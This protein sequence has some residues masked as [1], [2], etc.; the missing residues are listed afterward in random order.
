MKKSLLITALLIFASALSF[1]Q[2]TNGLVAYY[3]FNGNANDSSG[4]G[5]HATT[6]TAISVDDR[7]GNPNMAYWF[8][9]SNATYIEVPHNSLLN[10]NKSKTVSAWYRIDSVPKNWYPAII[11]KESV[12]SNYPTF[13]IQFNIDPAYSARNRNK[14]GF[15][16]GNGSTNKLLSTQE[17]ITDSSKFTKWVHIVGTYSYTSGYQKIYYNGMLSD[18]VFLGAYTSD[19]STKVMQIGRSTSVGNFN[20]NNFLGYIDDIRLYNRELDATEISDLFNESNPILSVKSVNILDVTKVYPNPAT[21]EVYIS[22]IS[23][24]TTLKIYDVN[25]KLCKTS[26]LSF[27]TNTINVSELKAGVYVIQL[28]ANGF[29]KNHKLIIN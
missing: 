29:S 3:P 27:E 4:N 20:G 28:Q 11:Y 24:Q 26:T 7:F 13:G 22:N 14:V 17:S 15:F 18:S 6:N 23:E 19:T 5:I 8:G 1:A 9:G 25:G 12:T 10:L 16:F 21:S 2:T